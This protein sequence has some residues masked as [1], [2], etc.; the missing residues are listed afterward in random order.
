MQT[1][2]DNYQIM[3]QQAQ[4]LFLTYDQSAIIEKSPVSFDDGYLYL[5]VLDQTCRI[6]RKS[7]ELCW[8]APDGS[9]VPSNIPSDRLTVF[10]YLCD[11]KKDR[12]LSGSWQAMANF[13][14]LFH[15][16]LLE[17]AHPTVLEQTIDL[18]PDLFHAACQKLHGTPFPNCDI[19]YKISFFPDM[20]MVLQFWHSDEEFP[21]QL[22][23]FWDKNALSYLRYETMYYAVG[24]LQNRLLA[25][26]GA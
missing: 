14:H 16:G 7:G 17:D 10:D 12:T 21:A 8:S 6:D 19:G 24:I 9:F 11:A 18:H 3:A 1:K 15:T 26:M 13:G 22:R 25:I 4:Q 5:P 20:P 23:Y 2:P